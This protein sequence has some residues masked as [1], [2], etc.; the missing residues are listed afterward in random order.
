MRPPRKG[1]AAIADLTYRAH[2]KQM[3]ATNTTFQRFVLE[4]FGDAGIYLPSYRQGSPNDTAFWEGRRALG[5]EVLHKLK[6]L[7]PNLLGI[8]EATGYRLVIERPDP[9]GAQDETLS[10]EPNE[11]S[12]EEA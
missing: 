11:P 6:N 3:V 8:L 1:A 4:L 10:D 2:L 7:E 12:D 5:L 9:I